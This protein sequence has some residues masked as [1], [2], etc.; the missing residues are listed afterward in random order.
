MKKISCDIIL[1]LVGEIRQLFYQGNRINFF[2]EKIPITFNCEN[3]E[4]LPS[5]SPLE[6]LHYTWN[7]N[8]TSKNF[9]GIV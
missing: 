6:K 2:N 3:A 5:A 9:S 1:W 7:V 4:Y 8:V